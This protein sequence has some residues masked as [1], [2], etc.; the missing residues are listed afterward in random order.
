VTVGIISA[1]GR[2]IG[3]GPYDDFLQTDAAINPGNSGGPLFNMKGEVVGINT[4]II[5]Q[6]QG[7]GFAIPSNLA[8]ELLPQLEAGK[9]VRGWLGVMIQDLTPELAKSFKLSDQ[10][11][12]LIADVT[13]EGPAKDAGLK[14]GD[15]VTRFNGKEVA[16]AHALSRMVAAAAPGTKVAVDIIRDGKPQSVKIAIGT[17]PQHPREAQAS[18]EKP[19]T[20][21]LAVQDITPEVAQ[22]LGLDAD[23]RGVVITAVQPDS[24]AADAELQPGDVIQEVDRQKVKDVNDFNKTLDKAR[25]GQNLLLLIKRD[26]DSVFVVLQAGS[27]R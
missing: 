10:S 1:K 26:G 12:V 23:E 6:G 5:A 15:V 2:I 13:Q 18:P 24:P 27:D 9:I 3:A 22:S 16:N 11:G 8:K 21:G 25:P 4:A 17:M 20:W 7:I 14:G 19:G